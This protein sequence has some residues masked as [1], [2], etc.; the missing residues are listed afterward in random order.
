MIDQPDERVS[1]PPFSSAPSKAEAISAMNVGIR[2]VV[3][4]E[5]A[6]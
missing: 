1:R 5:S 3:Q 6:T 2:V 4:T